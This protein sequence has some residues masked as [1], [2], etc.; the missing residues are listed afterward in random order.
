[1][2]AFP[3]TGS[4]SGSSRRTPSTAAATRAATARYGFTSPPGTR[5]STRSDGPRPISRNAQ[6]RLSGPQ[7][8]A[9]GAKLPGT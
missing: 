2:Y 1:M 9:V 5:H 8:T 3:F 7:A 4:G 6:V